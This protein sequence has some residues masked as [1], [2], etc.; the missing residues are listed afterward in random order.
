MTTCQHCQTE[1]TP[2]AIDG[3]MLRPYLPCCRPPTARRAG[4]CVRFLALQ[5]TQLPGRPV[6]GAD[7][8]LRRPSRPIVPDAKWPGMYRVA[9]PDGE[10][11]RDG[12]SDEGEGCYMLQSKPAIGK[13]K[14]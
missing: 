1:F 5:A 14:C 4:P 2:T 3:Q 6:S 11:E 9:R 7:V 13:E 12:Q 10:R 8:T